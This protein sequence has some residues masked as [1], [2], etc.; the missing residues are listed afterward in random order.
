MVRYRSWPTIKATCLV[1]CRKHLSRRNFFLDNNMH[2]IRKDIRNEASWANR[3]LAMPSVGHLGNVP[4]THWFDD[5]SPSYSIA[6]FYLTPQSRKR[7]NHLI[8]SIP[9]HD[10][11]QVFWSIQS[12][13]A[14]SRAVL[15][16][17]FFSPNRWYIAS[18]NFD[19][20]SL[21]ITILSCPINTYCTSYLDINLSLYLDTN[22]YLSS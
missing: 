11:I 1:R 9:R 5:P 19:S 13:I 3:H 17:P 7:Y 21:S 2:Y 8:A 18:R 14:S 10:T 12:C 20:N 4:Q 16:T 6:S 22:N 15:I